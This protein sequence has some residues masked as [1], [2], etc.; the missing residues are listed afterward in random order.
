MSFISID[1]SG[2]FAKDKISVEKALPTPKQYAG[3]KFKEYVWCNPNELITQSSLGFTDNSVRLGGTPDNEEL[4]A[5]L[6]KG[7]DTSKRIY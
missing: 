6:A 7:L 2:V 3:W 5:L 1:K 4:E